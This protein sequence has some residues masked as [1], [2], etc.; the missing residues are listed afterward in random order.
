MAVT[1]RWLG[2]VDYLELVGQQV[3]ALELCKFGTG[4]KGMDSKA[5]ISGP[6]RCWEQIQLLF[7]SN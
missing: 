5:N 4:V 6:N 3:K 1:G 2:M 7:L